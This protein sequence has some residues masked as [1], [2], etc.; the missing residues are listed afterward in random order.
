MVSKNLALV[1]I[2]LAANVFLLGQPNLKAAAQG[3]AKFDGSWEVMA[4]TKEYKN[5][6]GSTAQFVSTSI[7]GLAAL[8]S[9]DAFV[10]VLW[11]R[12]SRDPLAAVKLGSFRFVGLFGI[13]SFLCA[14][15]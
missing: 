7:L 12:I 4:D 14:F 6:D 1:A 8:L 3:P 2:G 11:I 5:T 15:A 13:S 10:L 9:I